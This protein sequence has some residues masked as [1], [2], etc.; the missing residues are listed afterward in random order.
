MGE[1]ITQVFSFIR[2]GNIDL[3]FVALSQVIQEEKK[4]YWLIPNQ[5]HNPIKQDAVILKTGDHCSRF[6]KYIKSDDVKLILKSYGYI[7]N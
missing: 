3:G 5:Y 4:N 1:N 7:W 2:S 6:V